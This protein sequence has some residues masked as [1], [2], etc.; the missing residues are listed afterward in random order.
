MSRPTVHDVAREAGV[1]LATVDRVLN[2]RPGVRA[3][4]VSKVKDAVRALGYSRDVAAAN[5]ARQRSYRFAF[6]LPEATS[7][8]LR[9]VHAAIEDVRPTSL[10]DRV[11]LEVRSPPAFDPHAIARSI[12]ALQDGAVDGIAVMS[13]ESPQVRDALK[14]ASE[15]G[16]ET[17]AVISDLPSTDRRYFVGIDNIAAGRTAGRLMGRFLNRIDGRVV[18]IAGSMMARDHLE[19]RLGF[20]QVIG[21]DFSNLETLPSLEG[22]DDPDEVYTLVGNAFRNF[23]DIA[24]VYCFGGGVTGMLRALDDLG[25]GDKV[26]VIAHELTPA[27][28][29]ALAAGTLDAVITQDVSHIVRSAIRILRASCDDRDIIESQERIRIEIILKENMI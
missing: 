14:R 29:D 23:N 11:S 7:S 12:A 28:R 27:A 15:H 13:A 22:H 9:S 2:D 25:V 19:R 8:F 18:A 21:R 17:V 20:D 5:L 26:V 24:G 4:T 10:I 16:V 6:V 3:A 1:S